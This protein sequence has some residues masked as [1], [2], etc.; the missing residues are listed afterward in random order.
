M[1]G[2]EGLTTKNLLYFIS[3]KNAIQHQHLGISRVGLDGT[4]DQKTWW[5][6]I[7]TISLFTSLV[8][9]SRTHRFKLRN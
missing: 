6:D 2:S 3:Y 9:L 4:L 5:Y 7:T 8:S 1:M